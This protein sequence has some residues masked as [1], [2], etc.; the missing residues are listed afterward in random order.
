MSVTTEGFLPTDYADRRAAIATRFVGLAGGNVATDEGTVEGD[1]ITLL[2]LTAQQTEDQLVL[3]YASS[4]LREAAGAFLDRV[5]EPIVG[6]RR[7]A[8][9]SIAAVPL[10]GTP[11]LAITVGSAIIPAGSDVR[12]VLVTEVILGGGGTGTGNFQAQTVGPIAA[13]SGTTW[14]ISTPI[15]GWTSAGPSLVDATVGSLEE[16][17]E[18]YR[19]RAFEAQRSGQPARDVWRVD[20]VTLVS[21]I[22]NQTDVPDAYWLSTH[23]IELL[24]VGGTDAAVAAAIHG[25]RAPGVN[26]VGNTTEV[27]AVDNYIGGNVSVLFSRPVEVDIY[28]QITITKGEAYPLSVSADAITARKNAIVTALLAWAAT[29]LV[30]GADV[31]ADAVK[32][33]VFTT[34]PGVRAMAVVVGI[35]DPPVDAEVLIDVRD[36]AVMAS[37]RIAVVGA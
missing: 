36:V 19:R 32:A 7:R 11:A 16:D 3:T 13:V 2:A 22:E 29:A 28:V 21:I 27:I 1:I 37:G 15:A 26:T 4:L 20:G 9:G 5:A 18:T 14:T 34:I 17:D 10:V 33:A 8:V 23:W 25:S 6:Q 35:V 30:P 12:W 31:Y 24:V